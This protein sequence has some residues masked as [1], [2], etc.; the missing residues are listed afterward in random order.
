MKAA[1]SSCFETYFHFALL[2]IQNKWAHV[3]PY[4]HVNEAIVS[5]VVHI[6]LVCRH[7]SAPCSQCQLTV[8]CILVFICCDDEFSEVDSCFGGPLLLCKEFSIFIVN[9]IIVGNYNL[10]DLLVE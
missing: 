2:R 9:E 4:F 10:V 3:I 1:L 5:F 7:L 6:V 8:T